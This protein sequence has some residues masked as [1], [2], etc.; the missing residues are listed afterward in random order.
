MPFYNHQTD[1]LVRIITPSD[2][3]WQGWKGMSIRTYDGRNLMCYSCLG[4]Q[5]NNNYKNWNYID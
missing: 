3:G 4:K 5:F 2:V 1:K